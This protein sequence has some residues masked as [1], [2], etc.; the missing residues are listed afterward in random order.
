MNKLPKAR[1]ENIVVQSLEKETLIYDTITNQAFSLN[2]TSAKVFN[3]CD[4]QTSFDELQSK[5]KY[6]DELIYLALDELKKQNLLAVNA[7]YASPFAE[8]SRREVIRKVG[9]ATLVALPV[10]SSIIAPTSA[11]AASGGTTANC[12]VCTSNAQCASGNCRPAFPNN[13]TSICAA[14]AGGAFVGQ[15]GATFGAVNAQACS[16]AAT[17]QCCKGTGT[18]TNICTCN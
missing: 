8:M 7:E 12:Q 4:G 16:N 15:T 3:A 6:T 18:F 1:T 11:S 10:I 14:G 17:S 13:G 5:Y 9:F 2:E